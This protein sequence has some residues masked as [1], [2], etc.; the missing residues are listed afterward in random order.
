[1]QRI[2]LILFN[3]FWLIWCVSLHG[4]IKPQKII[5]DIFT[6]LLGFILYALGIINST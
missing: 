1:M 5:V 4:L 2:T 6:E 3:L